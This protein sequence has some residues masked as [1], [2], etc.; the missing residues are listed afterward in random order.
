MNLDLLGKIRVLHW[1]NYIFYIFSVFLCFTESFGQNYPEVVTIS[2][3][4]KK[5]H[6]ESNHLFVFRNLMELWIAYPWQ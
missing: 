6:Y 3:A 2:Q 4:F 5:V 1:K